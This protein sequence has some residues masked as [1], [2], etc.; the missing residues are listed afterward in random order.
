MLGSSIQLLWYG[1]VFVHLLAKMK[2]GS[3]PF[4]SGSWTQAEARMTRSTRNSWPHWHSSIKAPQALSRKLSLAKADESL[5]GLSP[6]AKG[7]IRHNHLARMLSFLGTHVRRKYPITMSFTSFSLVSLWAWISPFLRG[8][9]R[10]QQYII[11]FL[12][13]S[14][15]GL[16]E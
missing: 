3:R 12:L 1:M 9:F 15:Y 11:C 5:W 16:P 10:S 7:V 13:F 8:W 4:K 14:L 6:E 2:Y